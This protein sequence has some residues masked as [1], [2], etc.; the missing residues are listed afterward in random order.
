MRRE[1]AVRREVGRA[2]GSRPSALE[3][4]IK[5]EF[6]EA[7]EGIGKESRRGEGRGERGE[8]RGERGEGRGERGEGGQC[9]F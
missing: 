9:T 7:R 4:A 8:G 1:W 5:T 6:L 3:A 2:Q